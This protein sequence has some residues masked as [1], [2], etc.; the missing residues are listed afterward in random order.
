MA[1]VIEDGTG[2]INS[3]SYLSVDDADAYFTARGDDA[4][5]GADAVKEAAL[6]KATQYMDATYRWR[7]VISDTTQALGWPRSN[8]YD[9]EGRD[10][11]LVP[12]AVK[13]ACAELAK[14]ALSSDLA[15]DYSRNDLIKSVKAGSVEVEF[16]DDAP[17]TK[18]YTLAARILSGVT[19]GRV[20]GGVVA[21]A[22]VR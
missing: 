19:V 8:A 10:L 3:E 1:L 7:G 14:A 20:G 22:G 21:L 4:W 6:R 12:Q 16:D 5:T 18:V 9:H 15:A 11:N 13:D 2:L 17:R